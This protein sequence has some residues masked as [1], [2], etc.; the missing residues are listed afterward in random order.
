MSAQPAGSGLHLVDERPPGPGLD[1]YAFWLRANGCGEYTIEHR[2]NHIAEFARAHPGFPN[3]S[4]M[5]VTAWLGRE[6]YA[7]WTRATYY[8]NLRSYFAYAMEND[9]LSVD[10]MARM[11]RPRVPHG[12]PRPL[13]PEQ[14]EQVLG[15]ALTA[16]MRTW[17]TLGL[18]AGLR[19]HEIAKFAAEDVNRHSLYVLGKGGV[20]DQIPTHPKVWAEAQTRPKAGW[21]FPSRQ[22]LKQGQ[23]WVEGGHVSSMTISTATSRLFS[24]HGIEGSIHRCR[25]TYATELLRAGVNIRVV[26]EL[27]RHRSLDST[28]RYTA[29][30]EDELRD[31]ISRLGTR[32]DTV[33]YPRDAAAGEDATA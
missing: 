2:L 14:V 24:A 13:T 17:L 32:E 28:M 30:N 7:P 6:G 5:H 18:Y 15:G 33:R 23:G 25:H 19:A 3:V 27:M 20:G 22:S 4:A 1:D 31:G 10:P 21:W 8:G 29:V 12:S 11:R 9:L 26:Q 16:D